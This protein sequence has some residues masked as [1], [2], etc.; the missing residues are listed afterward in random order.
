[1]AAMAPDKSRSLHNFS[2]PPRLSWGAQ[3]LLRCSKINSA[4]G[5][6]AVDGEDH[7]YHR[8]PRSH[9]ATYDGSSSF[10]RSRRDLGEPDRKRRSLNSSPDNRLSASTVTIGRGFSG[11]EDDRIEVIREKLMIDLQ[12]EV[13]KIKNAIL[14]EGGDVETDPRPPLPPP[15]DSAAEDPRPWNLRTRRAACRE[16]H[17]NSGGDEPRLTASPPAAKLPRVRSDWDTERGNGGEKIQRTKFSVSLSREEIEED[18]LE[19]TRRRP[20]RKPKKRPKYIQKQLDTLFPGLWL[21][22]ITPDMYKVNENPE[23]Q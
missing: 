6:V 3:R 4:T 13:D 14:A 23:G 22:E 16:P 10:S 8:R 11:E 2:L 5:D 19:L 9:H 21:S 1:M 17:G 7:H 12:T 18:F 15:V 20:A